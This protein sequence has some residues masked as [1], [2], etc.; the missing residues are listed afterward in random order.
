[1][2]C[3]RSKFHINELMP[4]LQTKI[5]GVL[6]FLDRYIGGPTSTNNKQSARR[7]PFYIVAPCLIANIVG[8]FI[9]NISKCQLDGQGQGML[10]R[11][12]VGLTASL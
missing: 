5:H 3:L 7:G 12:F 11:V 1:M 6:Q 4:F 9:T 2:F 10:C 8:H